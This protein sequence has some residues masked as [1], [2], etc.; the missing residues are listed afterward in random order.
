VKVDWINHFF[1]WFIWKYESIIFFYYWIRYCFLF[2]CQKSTKKLKRRWTFK[3][4]S[5]NRNVKDIHNLFNKFWEYEL[6][7]F[8]K[9]DK[10]EQYIR[11]LMWSIGQN[12]PATH[13]FVHVT[14]NSNKHICVPFASIPLVTAMISWY[15]CDQPQ[16]L[17]T[18]DVW[19]N[20][21]R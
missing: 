9:K 21:S 15:I 3:L 14:W 5:H 11:N 7:I 12:P 4:S 10:M 18:Y 13:L 8:H 19:G 1:Y 16:N 17:P 20:I 6:Y 2:F